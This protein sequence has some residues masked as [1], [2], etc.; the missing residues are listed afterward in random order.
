MPTKSSAIKRRSSFTIARVL[1]HNSNN[2]HLSHNLGRDSSRGSGRVSVAS[3]GVALAT[4]MGA[5][6]SISRSIRGSKTHRRITSKVSLASN[7]KP[8]THT[9]GQL[10]ARNTTRTRVQ[11]A[12]VPGKNT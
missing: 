1:T 7:R 5:A 11:A 12:S 6:D 9:T 3:H 8:G 2:P 4:R 10:T